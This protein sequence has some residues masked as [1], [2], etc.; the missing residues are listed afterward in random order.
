MGRKGVEEKGKRGKGGE[1]GWGREKGNWGR[2]WGRRGK[3]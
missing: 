1:E 2:E 3:V